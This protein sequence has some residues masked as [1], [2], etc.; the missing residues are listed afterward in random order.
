MPAPSPISAS[1]PT[2]PRWSRFSRIFR[3]CSTIACDLLARRCGRRSRRRRRRARA[4]GWYR[5]CAPQRQAPAHRRARQDEQA[6]LDFAHDLPSRWLGTKN[7]AVQQIRPGCAAASVGAAGGVEFRRPR[8]RT[9]PRTVIWLL[10]GTPPRSP[11]ENRACGRPRAPPARRPRAAS[12]HDRDVVDG[13]LLA[14]QQAQARR[15][16]RAGRGMSG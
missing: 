5:P 6:C 7:T 4:P 12:A 2:A 13:P 3:P 16:R 11:G 8:R 14:D 10:T 15:C 1:A 9:R